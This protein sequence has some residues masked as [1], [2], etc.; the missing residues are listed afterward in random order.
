[1]L[2]LITTSAPQ[3]MDNPSISQKQSPQVANH[4]MM[5]HSYP[6]AGN[7]PFSQ[8]LQHLTPMMSPHIVNPND[9]TDLLYE[10][11]P[12]GLDDWQAPVDAVYRPHVVHHMNMPDDPKTI[13]ARNRTDDDNTAKLV[14]EDRSALSRSKPL[15]SKVQQSSLVTPTCGVVS[16]ESSSSGSPHILDQ[17]ECGDL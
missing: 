2:N 5:P 9:T 14:F 1:M 8:S 7:I 16:S 3:S 13:A 12:L 10:Y 17:V 4:Q 11:F 6:A 15:G